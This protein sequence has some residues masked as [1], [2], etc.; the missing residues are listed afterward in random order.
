MNKESQGALRAPEHRRP[1]AVCAEIER[2]ERIAKDVI[3]YLTAR[4]RRARRKDPLG[5]V[6]QVDRAAI[7]TTAA[8]ASVATAMA[9]SVAIATAVVS[10][11]AT[12]MAAASGGDRGPR[13]PRD[14]D[15]PASCD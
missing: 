5:D 14:D 11:A 10:G 3:R 8:A 4:V 12:A 9:V 15:A 1:S 7:A 6:A 13:R 2:Q